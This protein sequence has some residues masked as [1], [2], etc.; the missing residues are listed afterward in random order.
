VK[1]AQPHKELIRI[2][3][4]IRDLRL[5]STGTKT[6][7]DE[8][9]KEFRK[10][11][12][13]E[14]NLR[15]FNS[16]WKPY[17]GHSKWGKALEHVQFFIWKQITL[18]LKT[19]FS[20]RDVLICTDYYVP[21]I[22]LKAKHLVVFHDALFFDHPEY[23]NPIWLKLFKAIALPA[24]RRADVIIAP[25]YFSKDRLLLHEKG[26]E[27]KIEVVYQ[28]PKSFSEKNSLSLNSEKAIQKIN[29]RPYVLHVGVLEKR[30][31]IVNLIRAIHI[32][33]QS[34][35]VKL[36]LVGRP[37]PKIYN[38]SE[39]EILSTI[40]DLNMEEH[41]VFAGYAPDNDL[42]KLYSNAICY[43]FPS[44]YEGF[45]IPI[46]EAFQHRIPVAVADNTSLPEIGAS[47]VL[48]FNPYD[49]NKMADTIAVLINDVKLKQQLI[50]EGNLRFSQFSWENSA[51]EILTTAISTF[52]LI[53]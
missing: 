24:A 10:L 31:N 20:N 2:G 41:V 50:E 19:L 44:V 33:R 16:I 39:A 27:G 1:N 25:S 11:H 7:L 36:L 43:V 53:D 30:K 45:G 22:K 46:L 38:N 6:Y 3:V 15:E 8:L 47:A 49:V 18:P 21:L 26:F 35:D 29:G 32:L 4:D 51:K 40:K 5:A 37:N 23:Y 48:C 14:I 9:L 34:I 12:G 13:V 42:P 17:W 52:K 28:G